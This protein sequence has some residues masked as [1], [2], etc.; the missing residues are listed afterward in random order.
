MARPNSDVIVTGEER[1]Q[2]ESIARSRSL[3]HGLVRCAH[4]VLGSADGMGASE[5]ARRFGIS[6]PTVS[7]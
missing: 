4:I 5:L 6:R 1:D 3:L 2:L 7:L